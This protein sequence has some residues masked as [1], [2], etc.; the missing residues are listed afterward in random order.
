[1]AP[2]PPRPAIDL[3]CDR[4]DAALCPDLPEVVADPDGTASPD[5]ILALG[6]EDGRVHAACRA[7]IL[8]CVRCIERGRRAGVIR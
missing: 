5:T 3:S 7:V 1:M 2:L 8:D 4:C 6:P